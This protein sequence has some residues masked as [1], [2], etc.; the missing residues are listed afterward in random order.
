MKE[1][2]LKDQQ[3]AKDL[4][5]IV[6][7]YDKMDEPIRDR[8]V[9]RWRKLMNYWDSIQY[10][11]W[12]EQEGDW[13]TPDSINANR[14]DPG[15]VDPSLYA[16]VIN[17]YRAHGEVVISAM[18][19]SVPSVLFP[20]DDAD[21]PEDILTA[22]SY[23]KLSKLIQNH[24]HGELL[25]IKALYILFNQGVVFANNESKE[26]KDY[27]VIIEDILE[28]QRV[29]KRMYLCPDCAEIL[30]EDSEVMDNQEQPP[31]PELDDMDGGENVH[32]MNNMDQNEE[33]DDIICPQCSEEAGMEVRVQPEIEE[34]EE[35]EER[36]TGQEEKPKAREIID[37]YGPLNVK[38]PSWIRKQKDTPYLVLETEEHYAKLQETYKESA[39]FI[40][41]GENQDDSEN[42]SRG[43][44]S[45][46][47]DTGEDLLLVQRIWLRPWAMN[48]LGMDDQTK[49]RVEDLKKRFPNGCYCVIINRD[50]LVE[51]IPD[52]LD[53][54]WTISESPLSDVIHAQ[55][56]GQPLV[57]IQELTNEL[58][59]LT[60][61]NIEHSIPETYAD[62][63]TLNFEAYAKSEARPGQVYPVS[64]QPGESVSSSF[65]E[66]KGGTLSREV[67]LFGDRLEKNSQFVV[68]SLPSV[69][70][71]HIKGSDTAREYEISRNAALQRLS[72]TWRLVSSWWVQVMSKSVRSFAQNLI[73]DESW[74][75]KNGSSFVN[76]W[77]KRAEM[78]GNIGDASSESTE[79]LPVSWNQ[80][81]DVVLNILQMGNE[82]LNSV[83]YHPENASFISRLIG[84]PELYIPGDDDRNKQLMEIAKL[85]ITEPIEIPGEID[86][87]TGLMGAEQ[88][89]ST[90]QVDPDVDNHAIEAEICG[91][92]LKSDVGQD[93]KE[94]NPGGY[95]N[96]LAHK[97]EHDFFVMQAEMAEMDAAAAQTEDKSKG[98]E[99]GE[100]KEVGA[101]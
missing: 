101:V 51:A 53:E 44:S 28:S 72:I 21:D 49:D 4:V 63:E 98:T 10:L 79:S 91:A 74:A 97:K 45:Y 83:I 48:V 42:R 43:Y 14:A 11:W 82:E 73:G 41:P 80:K 90:I 94:S 86:P 23:T 38:V 68:G 22:K 20:P 17:I 7:H 30:A 15:F 3:F 65:H 99:D 33:A 56:I 36:V 85:I 70:G 76:V 59:N 84:L 93:A 100:L 58:A 19:S 75:E 81:R 92:W 12:S 5:D 95:A 27:G 35:D 69:F 39:E 9:R 13:R 6:K 77:I 47:G 25:L 34:Y 26:D 16:K 87:M 54:H 2:P 37:V 8:Q 40:K 29:K 67:E 71:G 78:T 89:L 18:S 96:V 61:E 31:E 50:M 1:E 24:N 66:V 88:M 57:P 60:L 52:D 32:P 62:T 46:H 64:K 55:P